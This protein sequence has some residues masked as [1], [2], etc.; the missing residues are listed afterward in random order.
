M[1]NCRR[2]CGTCP[3]R[4]P[5]PKGRSL[6]LNST[7]VPK[8]FADVWRWPS[9]S[10]PS[11]LMDKQPTTTDRP[12]AA[13]FGRT[14]PRRFP[15]REAWVA[16]THRLWVSTHKTQERSS[17]TEPC[18]RTDPA[19]PPGMLSSSAAGEQ[20]A[21]EVVAVN[22][23]SSRAASARVWPGWPDRQRP[24]SAH[25]PH[26]ACAARPQGVRDAGPSG[27]LHCDAAA[28]SR[29]ALRIPGPYPGEL[30]NK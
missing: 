15:C 13:Y 16:R 4:L 20:P 11:G 19:R 28:R 12:G 21:S 24:S 5:R 18:H 30:H 1:R 29:S 22:G 9:S 3:R 8:T 25:L 17:G 2:F 27:H 26:R 10:D 14:A 23:R 7:A 6:D